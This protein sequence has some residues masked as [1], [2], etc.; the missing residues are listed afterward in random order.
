MR[1]RGISFNSPVNSGEAGGHRSK[2]EVVL[3]QNYVLVLHLEKGVVM[4]LKLNRLSEAETL[5][6][7]LKEA[8]SLCFIGT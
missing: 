7:N 1:G 2:P 4:K 3:A 8:T 6:S 5:T